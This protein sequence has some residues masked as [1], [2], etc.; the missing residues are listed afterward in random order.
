MKRHSMAIL[1]GDFTENLKV[2]NFLLQAAS[3]TRLT[4]LQSNKHDFYPHGT[5]CVLILAESHI[6]VHTY[7]EDNKA[8]VDC[9]TCGAIDPQTVIVEYAN[10]MICEV[11]DMETFKRD[12]W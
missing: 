12:V 8:Y 4:V 3:N 7:P 5:T 2:Y 11:V 1:S 6:T 10:L 9:F